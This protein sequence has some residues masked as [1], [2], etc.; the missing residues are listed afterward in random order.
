MLCA[1]TIVFVFNTSYIYRDVENQPY[2]DAK[3]RE[4]ECIFV[5][6]NDDKAVTIN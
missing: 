3:G 6:V 4:T 2:V 1:Y 5:T